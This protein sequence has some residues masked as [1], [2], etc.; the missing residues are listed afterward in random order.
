[1]DVRLTAH[2]VNPPPV[3]TH[4]RWLRWPLVTAELKTWAKKLS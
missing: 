2:P 3:T 1:M 4:L